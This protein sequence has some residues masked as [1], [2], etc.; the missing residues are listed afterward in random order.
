MAV[1]AAKIR[2]LVQKAINTDIGDLKSSVTYVQVTPGN[3][4]PTTDTVSTTETTHSAVQCALVKLSEQD[5]DW[6][7]ANARGQK[8][9]I[10][11]LNL[12][13][14]PKEDDYLT[15]DGERWDVYK[16]KPLP[17]TPV[18]VLFLRAT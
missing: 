10:P 4:N 14:T 1:T 7:P 13:I 9:L 11:Y 17:G 3:Y 18:H 6:F 8:C 12:T 15:I 16:I 2:Q 5:L